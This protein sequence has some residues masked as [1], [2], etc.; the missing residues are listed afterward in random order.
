MDLICAKTRNCVAM[1]RRERAY[2][3]ATRYLI[4]EKGNRAV[5]SLHS[6]LHCG[7]TPGRA[8][9]LGASTFCSSKRQNYYRCNGTKSI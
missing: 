1:E 4:S 7:F 3:L 9:T 6:D 5:A 2:S 8:S